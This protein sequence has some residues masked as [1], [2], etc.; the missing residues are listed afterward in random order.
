MLDYAANATVYW[1]A[2]RLRQV[3]EDHYDNHKITT[4]YIAGVKY[5]I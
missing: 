1:P 5:I 2:T 4:Q 3:F